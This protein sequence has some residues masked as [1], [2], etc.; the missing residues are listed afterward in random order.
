MKKVINIEVTKLG[1]DDYRI[2]SEEVDNEVHSYQHFLCDMDTFRWFVGNEVA[3]DIIE[4]E[5]N[6]I[7][8]IQIQIG[9]ESK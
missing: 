2:N 1:D 6:S 3:H 8:K 9:V 4:L 7:A 5:I